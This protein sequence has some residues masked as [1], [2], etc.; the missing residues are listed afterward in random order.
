MTTKQK[1]KELVAKMKDQFFMERDNVKVL[2]AKQCALIC[3]DEIYKLNQLKVGRYEGERD[4][5]MYYS[6]WEDV[7]QEIEKI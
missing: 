1:A 7:K 6:Y 4:I 5:E 3:V 2:K